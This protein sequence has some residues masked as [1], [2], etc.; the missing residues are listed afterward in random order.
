MFYT[1]FRVCPIF[2]CILY[3]AKNK[4]KCEG[5]KSS[6]PKTFPKIWLNDQ[7]S[8]LFS[9]GLSSSEK[10]LNNPSYIFM[11]YVCIWSQYLVL[12]QSFYK[13]KINNNLVC[14]LFLNYKAKNNMIDYQTDCC[15]FNILITLD[16]KD[17]SIT[18]K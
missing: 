7:T 11:Y 12:N 15:H 16:K 4:Q 10:F 6:Q 17:F 18:I 5:L 3:A 9:E 14:I 1:K 13:I 8:D 2:W